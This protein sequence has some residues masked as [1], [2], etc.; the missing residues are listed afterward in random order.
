M[1]APCATICNHAVI[2]DAKFRHAKNA[3]SKTLWVVDRLRKMPFVCGLISKI[4]L[5]LKFD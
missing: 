5:A 3:L 4:C 1:R 2:R